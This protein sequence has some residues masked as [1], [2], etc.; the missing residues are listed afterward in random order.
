MR[1]ILLTFFL[2]LSSLA[3]AAQSNSIYIEDFEIV[4]DSVMEVSVMMAN[5]SPTRGLQLI[6]T[7]PQGLS[8]ESSELTPYSK[9]QH[10]S[11]VCEPK[12]DGYM[13]FVYSMNYVSY[14][15][16]TAAIVTLTIHAASSFKGGDIV[17]SKAFGS[18]MENKTIPFDGGTATVTVPAASLIGIPIDQQSDDN[19][20]F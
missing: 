11:M 9:S 19:R 6:V 18:S 7:L 15:V 16:D 3:A 13:V 1:H 5:E 2:V 20:F 12:G 14:P 10:M 8:L 17:I 4:P